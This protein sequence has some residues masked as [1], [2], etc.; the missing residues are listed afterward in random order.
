MTPTSIKSLVKSGRKVS[1]TI[2]EPSMPNAP[3]MPMRPSTPGGGAGPNSRHPGRGNVRPQEH[4]QRETQRRQHQSLPRSL[5]GGPGDDREH[6]GDPP[7][8]GTLLEDPGV[9]KSAD[10]DGRPPLPATREMRTSLVMTQNRSKSAK[11]PT[12]RVLSG[13]CTLPL[14]GRPSAHR[15]CP[16]GTETPYS[17]NPDTKT[18]HGSRRC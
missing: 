8:H 18:R 17:Q 1:M 4:D 15:N 12:P 10:G 3:R 5:I 6:H 2:S 9:Q 13:D 7:R 16:G 11:V 14:E